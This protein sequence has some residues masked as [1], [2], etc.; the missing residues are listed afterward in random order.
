MRKYFSEYCLKIRDISGR[1]LACTGLTHR[2]PLWTPP[3]CVQPQFLKSV[4]LAWL[5]RLP[6][7]RANSNASQLGGLRLRANS[8]NEPHVWLAFASEL[9]NKPPNWLA[10]ASC[11]SRERANFPEMPT[12]AGS[13]CIRIIPAF[14]C[15][16]MW[17]RSAQNWPRADSNQIWPQPQA[18]VK[19]SGLSSELFKNL[20]CFKHS[21]EVS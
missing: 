19:F 7:P 17:P 18:S 16:G 3:K 2:R 21:I 6:L 4:S 13:Y 20:K 8:K 15:G 5:A 1:A 11:A 10:F 12:S 9:K 14:R